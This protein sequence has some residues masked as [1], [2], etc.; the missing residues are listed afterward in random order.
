MDYSVFEAW[1]GFFCFR[2][3]HTQGENN[4]SAF[5]ALTVEKPTNFRLKVV[6]V[7]GV[8]SRWGIPIKNAKSAALSAF[9]FPNCLDFAFSAKFA[10]AS[11]NATNGTAVKCTECT[12]PCNQTVYEPTLSYAVLSTLSVGQILN[13]EDFDLEGKYK[14]ALETVQRVNPDVFTKDL[15]MLSTLERAYEEMERQV[16]PF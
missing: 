10:G 13:R 6:N 8:V 15:N 14:A 12:Q 5:H 2:K 9:P 11:R 7:H 16:F 4:F 1:A 3:L